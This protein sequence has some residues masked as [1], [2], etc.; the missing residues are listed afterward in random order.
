[1]ISYKKNPYSCIENQKG[2]CKSNI[3][4]CE[5]MISESKDPKVMYSTMWDRTMYY[6]NVSSILYFFTLH[7]YRRF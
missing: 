7:M 2:I 6:R 1:M 5:H 3:I 4:R